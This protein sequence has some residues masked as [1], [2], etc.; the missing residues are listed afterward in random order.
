M[1]TSAQ[2]DFFKFLYEEEDERRKR[3]LDQ[4]KNHLALATF[5]S[6]FILFVV[7]KLRPDSLPSG[8][9]FLAAAVSM[10]I[11]FLLSLLASAISPYEIANRPRNIIEGFGND[12][13]PD[14]VFYKSRILD[15]TVAIE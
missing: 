13:P 12:P 14:E 4:A 3:L 7:E 1:T 6:A 5:Y 2:F 15:F 10:V 8:L 11:A 9:I